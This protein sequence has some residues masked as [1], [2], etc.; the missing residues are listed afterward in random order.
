[1]FSDKGG[2]INFYSF[3]KHP[4]LWLFFVC[5]NSSK[6]WKKAWRQTAFNIDVH[7]Q[8]LSATNSN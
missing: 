6:N 7:D 1:M 4:A 8:G 3:Q 2:Q 5:S